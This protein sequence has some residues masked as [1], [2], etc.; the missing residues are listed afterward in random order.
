M[1]CFCIVVDEGMSSAD[2]KQIATSA[3][4]FS[5][6]IVESESKKEEL[7]AIIREQTPTHRRDAPAQ[8]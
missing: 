5:C 1:P 6:L 7:A 3:S 2:L 4:P 8:A